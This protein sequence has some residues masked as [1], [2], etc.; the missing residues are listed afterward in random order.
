M[1]IALVSCG[2]DT[3]S[4]AEPVGSALRI[5]CGVVP[6]AQG[7]NL[8]AEPA[9]N[10]T[11]LHSR[12]RSPGVAHNNLSRLPV[13]SAR[14]RRLI[15][16]VRAAAAAPAAAACLPLLH[17]NAVCCTVDGAVAPRAMGAVKKGSTHSEARHLMTCWA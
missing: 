17:V 16:Q 7:L 9:W 12:P 10:W 13:H 11:L 4:A 2:Q 1:T 8:Q 3:I 14:P 6:T 5:V 15:A